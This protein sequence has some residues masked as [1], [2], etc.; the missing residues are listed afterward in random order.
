[1]GFKIFT[2]TLHISYTKEDIWRNI[3]GVNFVFCCCNLS[4]KQYLFLKNVK[5]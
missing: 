4:F 5:I 1:V 3:Y 2:K